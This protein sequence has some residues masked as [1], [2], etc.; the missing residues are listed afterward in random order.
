MIRTGIG[1]WSFAGWRGGVFYPEGLRASD[2][3]AFATRAVGA[4]EINATFHRLQKPE[5][6][7]AWHA[8]APEGFVYSLKGS[9]FVTNRKI[10]ASAA[11]PIGRF[12]DQG[13][14]ELGAKLGPIAWQL[15][16]TKRFEA[17]DVAAFFALL[18]RE[19]Q[20]IPLRHAIEVGHES[21][22]C[23]EFVEIARDAGVAIVWS[24]AAGRVRIPDR[25]APFAYLRLQNLAADCPTGYPPAELERIAAMCQAWAAGDAPSGPPYAGS[26]ADSVGKAGEI[27]AFMINGAKERAPA[28]ALA[29]AE[30]L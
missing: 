23:A 27:Y 26:R 28:A 1:G 4:I 22:A 16:A 21:F 8:A 3:L 29:L 30:R 2:E 11:E 5:S 7:R 18:P 10:L 14:V 19:H 9:R 12:M 17:D 24:E 13:L 6:F 20:G 15:A 25:T